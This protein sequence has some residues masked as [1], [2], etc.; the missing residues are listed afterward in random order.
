MQNS[1][2][3]REV[4]SGSF[5]AENRTQRKRGEHQAKNGYGE[6]GGGLVFRQVQ[7]ARRTMQVR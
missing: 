3:A 6:W 5:I 4:R 1:Q 2:R 7:R